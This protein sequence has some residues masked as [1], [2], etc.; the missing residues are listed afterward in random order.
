LFRRLRYKITA[1]FAALMVVVMALVLLVVNVLVSRNTNTVIEQ[2]FNEARRL[3]ERQLQGGIDRLTSFGMVVSRDPRLT[4]ATSTGD[5]LTVLD[6]AA[7][8]QSQVK[9]D[10]LTVVDEMGRVLARVH[11]PDRWGDDQNADPMIADA[12]KGQTQA[13]LLTGRDSLYQ[14]VTVPIV[15]GGHK[16]SGA[17]QLAFRIDDKF[18]REVNFTGTDISFLVGNQIVA[19]SLSAEHQIELEAFIGNPRA[20][21][22]MRSTRDG[23]AGAPLDVVLRGERYRCAVVNLPIPEA[24]YVI[25]RSIDREKAYLVQ[26]QWLLVLVGFVSLGIATFVS[27]F[28]ARGIARPVSQLA[29][30]SAR[31]A[32]GDYEV[33]FEST[34]RDEIGALAESFNHMTDSLRKYVEELQNHRRNLERKVEERTAE[35]A[36]ANRELELRNV[37]LSELSE[38]SL[39]SFHDQKQL[40]TAVTD[41]ARALLEADL[42]VLGK[43]DDGDDCRLFS[44]SSENERFS[45]ED[46]NLGFLKHYYKQDP[47]REVLILQI[48]ETVDG[49]SKGSGETVTFRSFVRT[50]VTVNERHFASLCLLSRRPDAFSPQDVEVLGILRRILA[51]EIERSEWERQILAYAAEVEKANRAKSQFLANM[52]HELRTPLNAIIGFSE[53]MDTGSPGQLNDKQKRYVYNILTSGRHLLAL[54]NDILDLS[55]VEAGMLDM[56]PERFILADALLSTESLI[57]GYAAKKKVTITF[58]CSE[59]ISMLKADQT[60]FKQILFNVLSNAV[61]FTPEGGSI[62]LSAGPLE[63]ISRYEKTANLEPGPYLMVSVKDSGIGIAPEDHDKVWGEFQQVDSSYT[64]KQEGSGLGMTLTRRLVEMQGGA[65]WFE[66]QAGAGTTFHFVLPVEGVKAEQP[67]LAGRKSD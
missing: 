1:Y 55:K 27:V 8:L 56:N 65:I 46:G 42:A 14:V 12:L 54:I 9:S 44:V 47:D 21:A 53:L 38:L 50:L 16:I 30:L 66:S 26:L 13:G 58:N 35:L 36:A 51:A 20:G 57:R 34:A 28:L 24:H 22:G 18:A 63:D 6:L 62:E 39:A 33:S 59:K 43:L 19:S 3:F 41:T 2:R 15:S 10:Q 31:V 32:G 7:T 48:E 40:F 60:R 4:A 45:A 11:E 23:S 37:R 52:S 29:E 64:R 67:P 49:G 25:Q 61:K 5:H 17:L